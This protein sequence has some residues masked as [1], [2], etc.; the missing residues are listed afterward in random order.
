M[1]YSSTL[2]AKQ[3]L[4]NWPDSK[5]LSL[6]AIDYIL[7]KEAVRIMKRRTL[8]KVCFTYSS[9]NQTCNCT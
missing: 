3:L 2:R 5:K 9:T 6:D 4:T 8:C 1:S 7:D